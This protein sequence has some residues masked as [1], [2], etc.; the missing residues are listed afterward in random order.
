VALD[1]LL[2]SLNEVKKIEVADMSAPARAVVDHLG[3]LSSLDSWSTLVFSSDSDLH[4]F[5]TRGDRFPNLRNST[6]ITMDFGTAAAIVESM[7]C[8]FESLDIALS[9][10]KT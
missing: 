9:D 3:N 10:G 7:V 6:F 4:S 2:L 5:T 1:A 8:P